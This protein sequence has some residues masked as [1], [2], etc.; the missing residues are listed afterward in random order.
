[1]PWPTWS[2]DGS[3]VLFWSFHQKVVNLTTGNRTD[4]RNFDLYSA[5]FKRPDPPHSLTI[6]RTPTHHKLTWRSGRFHKEIKEYRIFLSESLVTIPGVP[7]AVV[8]VVRTLLRE[9]TSGMIGADGT[10]IPVDSTEGF[11]D[12]PVIEIEGLAPSHASEIVSCAGKTRTAFINCQ[13]GSQGTEPSRHWNDSFVWKYTETY[14]HPLDEQDRGQF[15]IRAV[16]WSG[17][18]SEFSATSIQPEAPAICGN[19]TCDAGEDTVSCPA[20]CPAGGGPVCGNNLAEGREQC[21]GGNTIN[22]DGCRGDCGAVETGC[23]DGFVCGTEACD[24][25]NTTVGDGCSATCAN[26]VQPSCGDG[27]LQQGE[28]CDD[29]NMNSGDGCSATCRTEGPAG[30]DQPT[31]IMPEP[32]P[33]VPPPGRPTRGGCTLIS[34]SLLTN[35]FSPGC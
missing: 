19:G 34:S 21:D 16:E 28:D 18:E 35:C 25:G 29:G 22:C 12:N 31:G 4:L 26:E 1:Y 17:L 15:F 7:L 3:K 13:R 14:E 20:D 2:P 23:G 33:I 6:L 32:A 30:E 9:E 11:P 5:I 8:P 24:D 27:T 10:T